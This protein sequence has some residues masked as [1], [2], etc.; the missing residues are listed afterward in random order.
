VT[1]TPT[2]TATATATP[3]P[4]PSEPKIDPAV[5]AR[6]RAFNDRVR[7]ETVSL[8]D[9]KVVNETTVGYIVDQN[10]NETLD[11]MFHGEAMPV[12]QAAALEM[13]SMDDPPQRVVFHIIDNDR[14]RIFTSSFTVDDARAYEN[15]TLMPTDFRGLLRDKA[16]Y[17]NNATLD[18]IKTLLVW[19]TGDRARNSYIKGIVNAARNTKLGTS[20]NITATSLHNESYYFNEDNISINQGTSI[21]ITVQHPRDGGNESYAYGFFNEDLR[22]ATNGVLLDTWGEVTYYR[23][24]GNPPGGLQIRYI[25]LN[26]TLYQT[27]II[28]DDYGYAYESGQIGPIGLI[29]A[30]KT[31]QHNGGTAIE[32]R[33]G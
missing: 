24:F 13:A 30:L 11:Q 17:Y 33:G 3:T 23:T 7:N 10:T 22:A 5:K 21:S 29:R 27:R 31:E 6:Y 18:D 32:K 15:R 26:G 19:E 25:D 2:A 12:P 20:M 1:A 14:T 8:V 4:T 28:A 9:S 16:T